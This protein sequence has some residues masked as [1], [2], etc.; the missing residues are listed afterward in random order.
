MSEKG[1]EVEKQEEEKDVKYEYR[2]GDCLKVAGLFGAA[3]L[4]VVFDLTKEYGDK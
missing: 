3:I 4:A 2:T 1:D